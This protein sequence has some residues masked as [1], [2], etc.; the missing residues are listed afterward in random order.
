MSE[1]VTFGTVVILE[2]PRLPYDCRHTPTG[3]ADTAGL[4]Q[5]N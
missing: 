2:P 3:V 5:L 4:A 1:C